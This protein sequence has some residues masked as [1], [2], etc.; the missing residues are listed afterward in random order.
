MR[1]IKKS[2][3]GV[4]LKSV[5][6]KAQARIKRIL[7]IPDRREVI[8]EP[9]VMDL[10]IEGVPGR[11][12]IGTPQAAE[13]YDPIKP[14]AK[15]EYEWVTQNVPLRDQKIIDVGAHHGHYAL[16]FNI[17][18]DR[19]AHVVA[20]DPYP[21]NCL[22][23]ELNMLLN[24]CPVEIVQC[25][26]AARDGEVHFSRE[27]NGRIIPDGGIVV[28]ARTLDSILPGANV[29]KLDVEGA[30]Y[31]IIPQAIDRMESVHTWI[32]EIHP[33]NNP[34]PDELANLFLSRQYEVLHLNRD[35]MR[36]EPY[37]MNMDWEIHAT[38][39][40]RRE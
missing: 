20:V 10:D 6:K 26:V 14:Y 36:V 16:V 34:H 38:I 5:Y 39:I 27:S 37:R 8:F 25:A 19:S 11:F 4:F 35:P 22:L 28:A 3:M 7:R 2:G 12:F 13:W 30:E 40:A 29:V 18:S 15:L 17:G 33:Y 1:A 31:Q 24:G 9:Y 23:V 21:M 32:V